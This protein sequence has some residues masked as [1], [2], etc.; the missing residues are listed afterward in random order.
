[1][2][3]VSIMAPGQTAATSTSVTV[4]SG[5]PAYLA[6]YTDVGSPV[7]DGVS[8][9]VLRQTEAGFFVLF[10]LPVLG[11]VTLNSEMTVL[12]LTIPGTYQVV[13]PNITEFLVNVGVEQDS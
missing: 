9:D 11:R 6:L 2:S 1:M 12:T 3:A 7:P 4:V 10:Y 8:F 5:T 13:R